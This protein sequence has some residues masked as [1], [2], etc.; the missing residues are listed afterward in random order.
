M[1]GLEAH[2]HEAHRVGADVDV[3][4]RLGG[5]GRARRRRALRRRLGGHVRPWPSSWPSSLGALRLAALLACAFLRRRGPRSASRGRFA[6]AV[7]ADV[8]LGD[9]ALLAALAAAVLPLLAAELVLELGHRSLPSGAWWCRDT[10]GERC[11]N[12]DGRRPRCGGRRPSGGTSV[13]RG[14]A[15]GAEGVELDVVGDRVGH[16]GAGGDVVEGV[17]AATSSSTQPLSG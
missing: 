16:V 5:D 11:E 8:G 10:A 13:A 12:A 9:L 3:G 17:P 7:L 2:D 4:D 6:V 14:R 15:S 1:A